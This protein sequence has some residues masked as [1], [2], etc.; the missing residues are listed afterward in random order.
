[1]E[2]VIAAR[3][4]SKSFRVYA[5]PKDML[6]EFVTRRAR[7]SEFPALTDVSF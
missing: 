1:M 5:H 4:L 6:L 3:A 2:P 7:H